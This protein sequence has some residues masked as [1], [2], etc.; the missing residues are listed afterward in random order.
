MEDHAPGGG[1]ASR[2]SS[3]GC[4][5]RSPL[6]LL[7]LAPRQQPGKNASWQAAKVTQE[8]RM[9]TQQTRLLCRVGLALTMIV[10]PV[11]LKRFMLGSWRDEAVYRLSLQASWLV[12]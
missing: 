2:R 8:T 3:S 11:L 9:G 7:P 10:A 12:P 4:C 6:H 1:G 5:A